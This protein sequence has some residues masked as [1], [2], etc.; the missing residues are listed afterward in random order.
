MIVFLAHVIMIE[1]EKCPLDSNPVLIMK[2][3]YAR[4]P[5]G[6]LFHTTSLFQYPLKSLENL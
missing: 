3:L 1:L 5:Q 6:N 2:K 4:L